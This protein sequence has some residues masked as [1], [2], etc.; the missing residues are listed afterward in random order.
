MISGVFVYLTYLEYTNW[1]V[2]YNIT[3]L[4]FIDKYVASIYFN[5]TTIFTIGYGDIISVNRYENVYN[6]LL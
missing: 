1:L 3:D 2:R 4:D 5:H 6:L